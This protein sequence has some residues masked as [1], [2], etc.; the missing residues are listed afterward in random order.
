M[1]TNWLKR[2]AEGAVVGRRGEADGIAEDIVN[3]DVFCVG[4][5]C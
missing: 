2:E 3:F 4:V 5:V 1:K